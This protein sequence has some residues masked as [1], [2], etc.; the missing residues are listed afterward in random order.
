MRRFEPFT[1]IVPMSLAYVSTDASEFAIHAYIYLALEFAG[2]DVRAEIIFHVA[3]DP[4][5]REWTRRRNRKKAHTRFD[6]AVFHHETLMALVEVKTSSECWKK[7]GGT[8]QQKRYCSFGVP[9]F[10]VWDRAHVELLEDALD[11]MRAEIDAKM[12]DE[13]GDH[14]YHFRHK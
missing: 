1:D 9:V 14:T 11:D 3:N 8:R 4:E 13:A 10:M 7:E 12:W 6:I 5:V 2:F